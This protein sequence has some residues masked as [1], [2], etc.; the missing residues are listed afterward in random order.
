LHHIAR[1][2]TALLLIASLAACAGIPQRPPRLA[3][4][5]YACMRAVLNGKLPADLPDKRAH[6]IAGGLIARY[7]SITEAY[8]AG[9]SKEMRDVLGRGDAEWSDWSADRAGIGCAR[10]VADDSA[11]GV[12]CSARGY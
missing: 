4:S 2:A 6:C 1:I 5:S 8:L 9:A 7:C 10:G 11:I 12:C 3:P